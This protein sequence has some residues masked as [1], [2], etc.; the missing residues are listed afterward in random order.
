MPRPG[1]KITVYRVSTQST[2]KKTIDDRLET[3]DPRDPTPKAGKLRPRLAPA[4]KTAGLVTWQ[5]GSALHCF[6]LTAS[7]LQEQGLRTG[8]LV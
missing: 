5:S 2:T 8:L 4:A 1:R 3:A 6:A 7:G